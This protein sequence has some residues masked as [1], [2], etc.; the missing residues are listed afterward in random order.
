MLQRLWI[1]SAWYRKII[2]KLYG[3][4]NMPH[5]LSFPIGILA[6]FDIHYILYDEQGDVISGYN[7]L[8]E[9]VS[10]KLKYG[11]SVLYE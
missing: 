10:N 11:I 6:N 2:H 8:R 7:T 9:A 5:K 1:Q 4:E 3:L